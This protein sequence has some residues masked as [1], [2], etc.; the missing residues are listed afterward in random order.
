MRSSGVR[1]LSQMLPGGLRVL[2]GRFGGAPWALSGLLWELL[3]PFWVRFY[4]LWE[5]L[6]MLFGC[7]SGFGGRATAKTPQTLN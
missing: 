2:L 6:G 4:V 3:G 1:Q 7:F 5:S